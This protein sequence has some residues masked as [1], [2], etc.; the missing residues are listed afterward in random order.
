MREAVTALSAPDV[1]PEDHMRLG[2]CAQGAAIAL[3]DLDAWRTLVERHAAVVRAAG[4]L[5]Q[6]PVVLVGLGATTTWAGDFDASAAL[7]AESDAVTEAT[8]TRAPPFAALMLPALRGDEAA[9][10]P[11]IEATIA[12]ATAGGQGLTVGYTNWVTAILYNGLGRYAEALTAAQQASEDVLGALFVSLWALPELIESAVRSGNARLAAEPM[13]NLAASTRAGG[14]EFGLGYRG[15][16]PCPAQRRRDRRPALLRGD[17]AA[18]PYPTTGPTSARAYLL[19]G[20][21]LR[22]ENRR[23]EARDPVACRPRSALSDGRRG[24]RRTRPP[25]TCRPPANTSQSAPAGRPPR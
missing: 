4:A 9:A 22:R 12:A 24:V 8:G 18:L 15:P 21:W 23:A 25:R 16:L 1:V 11:L 13:A 19:Y 5:D 10:I 6:L 2:I 14:T 3:W 17:R 20:E 7:I